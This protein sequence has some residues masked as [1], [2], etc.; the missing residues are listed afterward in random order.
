MSLQS[1]IRYNK[2][3]QFLAQIDDLKKTG[4]EF[5]QKIAK[6]LERLYPDHFEVKDNSQT[7][8]RIVFF[9]L[10]LLVRLEIE[11]EQEEPGRVRIYLCGQTFKSLI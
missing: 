4:E 7:R 10:S 3:K 9:G 6:A 1:T 2:S 8:L 5:V 11:M